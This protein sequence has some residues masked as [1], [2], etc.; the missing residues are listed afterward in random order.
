MK[1]NYY[2]LWKPCLLLIFITKDHLKQQ[3]NNWFFLTYLIIVVWNGA[4]IFQSSI[5]AGDKCE[6]PEIVPSFCR[7]RKISIS[8]FCVVYCSLSFG[9]FSFRLICVWMFLL[10]FR[11]SLLLFR[12]IIK[13]RNVIILHLTWII[14]HQLNEKRYIL[15]ANVT[16]FR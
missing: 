8:M 3:A 1:F 15:Y 10:I 9:N 4:S 13:D 7:V 5:I 12:Y 14:E 16:A 6:V 11:A 2:V